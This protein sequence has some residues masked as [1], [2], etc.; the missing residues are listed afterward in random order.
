MSKPH[1]KVRFGPAVTVARFVEKAALRF[2]V[3]GTPYILE[4]ARFDE[5]RP[6]ET[7]QLVVWNRPA[8]P[9][10]VEWSSSPRVSWGASLLAPDW[11]NMLGGQANLGAGYV[12]QHR[13]D[14]SA[15]FPS[16]DEADMDDAAGF[17]KLMEVVQKIADLLGP[18]QTTSS[19]NN[20][21]QDMT[22]LLDIEMGTLF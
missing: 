4:L 21:Y 9:P 2:R 8:T 16:A 6:I 17:W 18:A 12:A 14:L 13:G 5:Y 19:S 10:P 11:D 7:L 22:D 20:G 3:K 15:F 1:R